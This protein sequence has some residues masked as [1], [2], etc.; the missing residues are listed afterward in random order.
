MSEKETAREQ[1]RGKARE[2]RG[3]VESVY[4]LRALVALNLWIESNA[5][6]LQHVHHTYR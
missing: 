1:D 6:Q 2:R 4:R 5:L 3:D